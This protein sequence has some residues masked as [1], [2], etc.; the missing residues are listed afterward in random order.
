MAIRVALAG[1]PNSGK[2]T[3]FNE[4]TG[5]TAH[6]GN[7]PGVTVEKKEGRYKKSKEPMNIIDLPG[8]YSL[9]P[10]TPEE[11]IS[12]NF[13]LEDNC[14]VIVNIVDGTNLER[15]LY[16]TTQIMEVGRPVVVALNMMD[17]V[18]KSGMKVD[19]AKLSQ[20]IG[21]PVVPISALRGK[22]VHDLMKQVEK[23]AEQGREENSILLD[24]PLR[25]NLQKAAQII[26]DA[27]VKH[28]I[29]HA[30]KAL[31]GDKLN[32]ESMPSQIR[33]ELA[34]LAAESAKLSEYGDVE[35]MTAD[36]RY[37][38]ITKYFTPL[39][40]KPKNN[41]GLTRSDK[42]DRVLTNRLLG[43]PIFLLLMYVVFHLT[44]GE[45][46]INEAVGIPGPGVWIQGLT[47]ELIGWI[48]GG[49]ETLLENAGAGE[50]VN[51]LVMGG[52]VDGVGAVMSFIP[53]ILLMFLF[54]SL[55]EDSGYMA[56][57]AF[58]MDRA[59]R[60]FGLS[61]KSFVPLLMGFG[62]S[63]P[64]FMATR[65][66]ETEKDRRITMML[67]PFM[68]CGAKAPIYA[69]IGGAIFADHTGVVTFGIYMLGIA[70]AIISGIILKLTVFKGEA[71][72]F[73][74]ELPSYHLPRLKN[75]L[76]HLWDKL[77][78]YV[79][80]AGTIILGSVI[81]IWFLANFG[82][83]EG[84][85]GLVEANSASSLLGIV[86]NAIKGFFIPMGFVSGEDGWK[87]AV[88]IL[89]GLIAKEAVVSTLGVLYGAG[90]LLEDDSEFT[91]NA[92][93][94]AVAAS[95]S[96]AAALAFM[97]FNLLSI[98]CMAAVGALRAEM[99]NKKWFFGT[100]LFW[101][102]VAWV[103]STLVYQIGNIF[104]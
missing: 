75:L 13:L 21:A 34:N 16:L 89:T 87:A 74:M 30:V 50:I 43:I 7:W 60:R 29:F 104:M 80:R 69:A 59:L 68:S 40:N 97:S 94:T 57:A 92:F 65:T 8:I 5:S 91:A 52:I 39:I 55:L 11:I 49:I 62:C 1:N 77:K 96:P 61:G 27:G 56:R 54:L 38:Y 73:I 46:L 48:G 42:I 4:L 84:A 25:E 35:A 26:R 3:L 102:V 17:Q 10:Y 32:E 6:V 33:G 20:A 44:F 47:E 98:P 28:P 22:G 83:E 58:I 23:S 9:S 12:R 66:L 82:F 88:A 85:F 72:P 81:V 14:D 18:E 37:S 100:L 19:A 70:V 86:G 24:S 71:A 45:F 101:V 2:T 15:N 36:L 78:G 93:A 103:V 95:F 79:I 76:L 31:E 67:T 99:K 64:A 51:G 41:E 53:Q 90:D 63:V